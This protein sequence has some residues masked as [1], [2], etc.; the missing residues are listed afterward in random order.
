M[1]LSNANKTKVYYLYFLNPVTNKITSRSCRTKLKSEALR[2]MKEFK[3]G[4][5]KKP[6][7][8]ISS[9]KLSTVR[10]KLLSHYKNNNSRNTF[11]S[12]R[13]S[14]DTLSRIIGDK[15]IISINKSDMEEFKL[16]RS[17]EVNF[18][19]T[20]ID[21]RNI[22]AMF[23]KLIEFE[24]LNHSG[25]KS[26][27]QYKIEKKKMLAIDTLDLDRILNSD[28]E[29]QLKQIIRFTLLTASRISEVL[30]IKLKD[31]DFEREVISIFQQKTNSFKTIPMTSGLINLLNE[32][33]D[34]GN[35]KN[36]FKM[37]DKESYLFFNKSKNLTTLRLRSDTVSKQFKKVMIKLNLNNNFKFHSLRHSAITELL[38]N[39]VPINVVKEI[40]GHKS[41]TTTMVYSHVNRDD[42]RQAVNSLSY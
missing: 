27:K 6:Q 20:N 13:N 3:I 12:Y 38:K 40:A 31:L 22:K 18:I 26:T 19:S 29:I 42:M 25:I 36:V 30:N 8:E 9:L 7:I 33:M 10:D 1:F 32:I 34:H 21:I 41:I 28:A 39:N 35:D 2:V 4:S 17:K 5:S 11:L 24:L 14:F 16:K 15:F 37:I 23:N